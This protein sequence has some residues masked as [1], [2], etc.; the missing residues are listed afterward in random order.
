MLLDLLAARWEKTPD[1]FSLFFIILGSKNPLEWY[2][3]SKATGP[4]NDNR[5]RKILQQISIVFFRLLLSLLLAEG[6][7]FYGAGRI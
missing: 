2:G 1:W 6:R 4:S 3:H 5:S 7:E